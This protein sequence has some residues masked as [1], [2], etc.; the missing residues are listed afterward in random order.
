MCGEDVGNL[1]SMHYFVCK[2]MAEECK[3]IEERGSMDESSQITCPKC[4]EQ[5]FPHLPCCQLVI[6]QEPEQ[7]KSRKKMHQIAT[8]LEWLRWLRKNNAP[9]ERVLEVLKADFE[10]ETKKVC[11]ENL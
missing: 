7:K 10:R 11:P 6:A 1:M 8:E 2:M 4:G 5:M 3:E 9:H